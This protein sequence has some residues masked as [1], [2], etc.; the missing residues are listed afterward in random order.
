MQGQF[1]I[2]WSKPSIGN[3]ELEAVQHVIK[4]GWLAHGVFSKKPAQFL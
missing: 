3:E 2:P 4:S 1:K